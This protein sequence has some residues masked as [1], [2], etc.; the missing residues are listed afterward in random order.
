[1]FDS[2]PYQ[3]V[4]SINVNQQDST[5]D[6]IEEPDV[7]TNLDIDIDKN[8]NINIETN[9]DT[10]THT[11]TNNNG[12]SVEIVNACHAM[13]HAVKSSPFTDEDLFFKSESLGTVVDP[14]CGGCKC[15]KC[16]IPGQKYNFKDQQEF[17]Y[18]QNK[19]I[20]DSE[21]KRWFTQYPWKTDRSAL[22]KNDRAA[23][24]S[25]AYTGKETTEESRPCKR[26]LQTNTS[27]G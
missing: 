14:R 2:V 22:P 21:L 7:D 5:R 9:I 25:I 4:S 8:I 20:Y 12:Q 11:N 6:A 24:Q 18:I 13:N 27:N 23:Y 17:D 10:N 1:M 15:G 16:A 3:E 26:I 19:L